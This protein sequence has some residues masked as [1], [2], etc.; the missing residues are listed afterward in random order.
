MPTHSLQV[1]PSLVSEMTSI[2]IEVAAGG[3][4]QRENRSRANRAGDASA[5]SI[6]NSAMNANTAIAPSEIGMP[7]HTFVR[8]TDEYGLI[9]ATWQPVEPGSAEAPGMNEQWME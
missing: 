2:A 3:R 1:V 7:P 5:R 4:S 8:R 6:A 9:I